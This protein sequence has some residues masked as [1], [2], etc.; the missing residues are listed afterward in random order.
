MTCTQAL[1]SLLLVAPCS[2]GGGQSMDV[3]IAEALANPDRL[4]SDRARDPLR[5]PDQVLAFF[6]IKPGMRVLDLFS[7]GGYYTEIVSR[8]V[9]ENGRVISQN[10][11][12]YMDY[13]KDEVTTRYADNRLANV[14]L[15]VTEGND[16]ALAPKSIDATLAILTWHDFYYSEEQ[17]NWP[18]VDEAGLISKLC[19]AMKPGA[20]LGIIDHIAAADVDAETAGKDLHRVDPQRVKDDFADSCFELEAEIMILRNPQDDVSKVAMDPAV[21]GKTDR[22]VYKFRRK[23]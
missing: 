23:K 17:F 14:E 3:A 12:A 4:E 10:N 11:Q 15:I 1:L 6:E 19:M 21:R 22:F 20:V 7:G 9:G 13:V 2:D 5:K 8:I 16:I 18:D